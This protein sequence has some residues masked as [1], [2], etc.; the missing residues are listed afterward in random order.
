MH[1]NTQF[2]HTVQI[3]LI[4]NLRLDDLLYDIFQRDDAHHFVEG[5]SVTFTVH[6]L[7]HSQVGLSCG[8]WEG[9]DDRLECFRNASSS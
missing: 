4:H 3:G 1:I 2:I 6:P 8:R 7:H 5:V 9:E